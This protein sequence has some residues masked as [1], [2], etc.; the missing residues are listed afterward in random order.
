MTRQAPVIVLL[1]ALAAAGCGED[2]GPPVVGP[3]IEFEKLVHEFGTISETEKYNTG[4]RF[5]NTGNDVLV[6]SQVKAACGCTVPT[7]SRTRF[8]PGE[9]DTIDVTF[10]PRGKRGDTD[11]Y[12][13]VVSNS[14]P[15]GVVKLKI[16]SV[17][18]SMVYFDR[19]HQ[20]GVIPLGEEVTSLVRLTYADPDLAITD[21]KVNSPFITPR[22]AA[23]GE[24]DSRVGYSGA[25]EL[26]V[27]KDMPWG[28][29]FATRLTFTAHGRP[30]LT[31]EP[32]EYE[33]TVFLQGRVERDLT[34]SPQIISLSLTRGQPF[35]GFL[36]VKSVSGLPF[37]A[38]GATVTESTMPGVQ[39]RVEPLGQSAYKVIVAGTTAN[40]H[41]QVRGV[42]EVSTDVPG[43][44]TIIVR[45]GGSVR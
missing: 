8:L 36:T 7:L 28:V 9:G 14:K 27:S 19:F 21:L 26:T 45:F 44:E 2:A 6:I 20:M 39:A 13:T 16:H 25:I 17:I 30:Q 12:I 1:A 43:E 5:T 34:F 29:I 33:Y 15:E 22:L 10:D 41:G 4:F 32:K 38:L 40:F 42:V 11:K 24:V 35:E 31:G 3:H 37:R 23:I 18:E